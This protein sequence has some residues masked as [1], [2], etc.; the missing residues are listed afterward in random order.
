MGSISEDRNGKMRRT[1]DGYKKGNNNEV[2]RRV[3]HSG[4]KEHVCYMTYCFSLT[5][6]RVSD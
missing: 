1:K 2:E 5:F 4:R 6:T 3:K